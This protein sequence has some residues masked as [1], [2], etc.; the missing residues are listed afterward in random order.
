MLITTI[1]FTFHIVEPQVCVYCTWPLIGQ[2][3]SNRI[4]LERA[5]A[6]VKSSDNDP[7]SDINVGSQP[8]KA[9][10]EDEMLGQGD[11]Q[12]HTFTWPSGCSDGESFH[13]IIIIILILLLPP[14]RGRLMFYVLKL[15]CSAVAE[16]EDEVRGP[17]R[18]GL[19]GHK[20]R[21][22]WLVIQPPT[23]PRRAT[24]RGL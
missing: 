22:S 2:I 6:Q 10:A 4:E 3:P 23:R 17:G 5:R 11:R 19:T 21:H 16:D 20:Q 13:L 1:W 9:C 15:I 12:V 7:L 14:Q 8:D 24:L 18:Q